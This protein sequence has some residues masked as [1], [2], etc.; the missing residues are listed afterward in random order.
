MLAPWKKSYA[1]C[2]QHIK[3]QRYLCWQSLYNQSYIVVNCVWESWT[4]KKAE[5]WRIGAFALCFWRRLLPVPWIARRS[6]QSILK[7]INDE[8]SLEGLMLELKHQYFGHLMLR[9]DSLETDSDAGEDWRWEKGK[10]ED[11]VVGWNHWLSGCEFEQTLGDGEGQGSLAC[12]S[13]WSRKE[14]N[15]TDLRNNNKYMYARSVT[16]VVSNS[17]QHCW[18]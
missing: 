10:T 16:T 12:C 7:E 15:T 2:R 14:S 18:L 9:T 3:K 6:N 1:K 4:I 13:P 11:E 5:H 17:W 8:Y